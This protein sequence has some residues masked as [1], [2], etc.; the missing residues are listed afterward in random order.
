MVC[1]LSALLVMPAC[2]SEWVVP[3]EAD[4]NIKCCDLGYDGNS[5]KI[6]APPWPGTHSVDGIGSITIEM[7]NDTHFNFTASGILINAVIVK[8][9]N[10]NVYNYTGSY[11]SPV[12]YDTILSPP[13]NPSNGQFPDISH[14]EFCYGEG[15]FTMTPTPTPTMTPPQTPTLTMTPTPT[16]PPTTVPE[17]P[18]F[19]APVIV[20][21]SLIMGAAILILAKRQ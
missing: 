3:E 1:I 18:V 17:F 20:V 19:A 12:P 7:V 14:I 11:G 16:P 15:E 5:F 2:A 8:A 9:C 10:S 13:V 4:Y 21:F 6:D